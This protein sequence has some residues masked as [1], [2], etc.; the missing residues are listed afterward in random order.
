M[1][2]GSVMSIVKIVARRAS[3]VPQGLSAKKKT[4]IRVYH[5]RNEGHTKSI[6]SYTDRNNIGVHTRA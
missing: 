4:H 1:R 2:F 3:S 5:E 6:K